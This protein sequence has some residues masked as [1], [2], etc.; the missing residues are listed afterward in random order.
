MYILFKSH[1]PPYPPTVYLFQP[2]LTYVV[3]SLMPWFMPTPFKKQ[4]IV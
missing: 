2:G 1:L 3:H 4:Y